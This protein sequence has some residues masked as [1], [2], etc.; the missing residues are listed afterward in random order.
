[1]LKQIWATA[2]T[3]FTYSV[4]NAFFVKCVDLTLRLNLYPKYV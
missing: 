1:M 2:R 3:H 4:D